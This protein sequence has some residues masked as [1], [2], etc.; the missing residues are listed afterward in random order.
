MYSVLNC[1]NVAKHTEFYLGQLQFHVFFTGNIGCFKNTLLQYS[2]CYCVASVT[3]TFTLKGEQTI[4]RSR[5]AA[6]A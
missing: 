2:T 4:Y 5:C 3:K 1:H 6:G